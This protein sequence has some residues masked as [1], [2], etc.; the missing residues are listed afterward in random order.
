MRSIRN[1][2]SALPPAVGSIVREKAV[3]VNNIEDPIT[4][5]FFLPSGNR[6]PNSELQGITDRD[7]NTQRSAILSTNWVVVKQLDARFR[8]RI[9]SDDGCAGSISP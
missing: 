1:L 2:N 7:F 5:Q 9:L 8:R 4:K 6:N 3:Q